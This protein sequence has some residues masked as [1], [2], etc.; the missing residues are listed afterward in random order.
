MGTLVTCLCN[1]CS[2]HIEFEEAQFDAQTI[3]CPHCGMDT[4]LY[5]PSVARRMPGSI[6]SDA[7]AA[8]PPIILSNHNHMLTVCKHCGAEISKEADACPKCGG[9]TRRRSKKFWRFIG[10]VAIGII[11]LLVIGSVLSSIESESRPP[12]KNIQ[13]S[14][15]TMGDDYLMIRNTGSEDWLS[16]DVYINGMPPFTY[17]TTIELEAGKSGKVS[18]RDFSKKNGERFNPD[19]HRVVEVWIGGGGYN[20]QKFGK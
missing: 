4:V 12:S 17:R 10:G 8:P 18:L 19:T 14:L 15:S 3:S 11:G 1:H 20:Y 6:R 9:I 13:A 7:V 2:G 5:I 16:V